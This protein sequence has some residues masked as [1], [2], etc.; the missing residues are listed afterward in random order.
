V[1]LSQTLPGSANAG[2]YCAPQ[3]ARAL[4]AEANN[5][6]NVAPQFAV[7]DTNANGNYDYP[8]GHR[9]TELTPARLAT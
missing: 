8:A 4:R 3:P 7:V 1:A 5:A 2:A 6:T 9:A